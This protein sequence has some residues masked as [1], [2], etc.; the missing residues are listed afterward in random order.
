MESSCTVNTANTDHSFD[1]LIVG[2]GLVGSTLACALGESG[3]RVGLLDRS[4]LNSNLKF[5]ND[6]DSRVVALSAA[7]KSLL[8]DLKIWQTIV[9]GRHCAYK[10][11]RVWDAD[12]TGAIYFD[13]KELDFPELGF[14]IE[15]RILLN[16]LHKKIV[17]I[18]AL[19]VLAHGEV[20]SIDP[21]EDNLQNLQRVTMKDGTMV[22]AKLIV[23]ADGG[24]STVRNLGNFETREWNYNHKAIVTTV[25]MSEPHNACA[26]QRFSDSGPLAFLPLDSGE[27][28][29]GGYFC[30]VV[31]SVVPDYAEHLLS[32]PS[33]LFNKELGR[34]ISHELGDVLWSEKLQSFPL[35]QMHARS[36]FCDGIVLVGDAA[37]TIHPLAG[38]GVN[39]GL[40]DVKALAEELNEARLKNRL[41]GDVI[42]LSRYQR[43]R[44]G[45]NLG[46]M[47]V[48]EGFKKLFGNRSPWAVWLRNFGLSRV[49]RLNLFKK[50][51][52]RGAMGLD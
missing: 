31:W 4:P 25:R 36:Y 35:R 9:Q 38:Q 45:H 43:A 48:M 12:G 5:E 20:V 6:F 1:I 16:A 11:M 3:Y 7:S 42:V 28:I 32:L 49:D 17:E 27:E 22:T 40:L 33:D 23:A 44:I 21:C 50:L 13:S 14:V 24:A 39:L 37:H 2:A 34:Q 18:D 10:S 52:A 41:P 26:F 19:K 15:S 8:Q 29:Q 46:M 51:L 30:S 47:G